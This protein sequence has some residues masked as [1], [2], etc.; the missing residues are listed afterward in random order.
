MAAFSNRPDLHDHTGMLESNVI[1][2]ALLFYTCVMSELEV[3][4]DMPPSADL[5]SLWS[6]LWKLDEYSKD[7]R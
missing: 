2:E 6:Q 5:R 3:A 4:A 7:S 1:S